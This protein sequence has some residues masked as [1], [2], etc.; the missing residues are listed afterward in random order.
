M[1]ISLSEHF[2]YKKLF[3]FTLPSIAMMIF[4]SVYGIVDG[5]FVSNIVG[6]TAFTAVNFIMPVLMITGSVG[7]MFGAGGSALVA[8]TLGEGDR[9]KANRIFSLIVYTSFIV[10]VI[11][12]ATGFVL[13]RTIAAALGAEG[14]MLENCVL[15]G[16]IVVSAIPMFMLQMEFQSLFITAEKPKLGLAVTVTAGVMNMIL[17]ALFMAV[18]RWGVAGAAAATAISQI[19][20][21][22]IPLVYFFHENDSLLRLG[23][24]KPDLRALGKTCSNGSSEFVSQGSM[25]LV[26][27]LYNTQLIRYAG[28]GGVAA[29]GVMM[30]VNLVFLA[31]FIGYSVGA[32]P[33]VGYNFGAKNH[34]ELKNLRRK[35]IRIIAA[36]SVIML[37]VSELSAGV[38]AGIFVGSNEELYALTVRGFKIFSIS[39]LFAGTNIF[40]SSFFTALN[41]GLISAL[42]SFL[43]T[44][45]FQISAVI[46]LPLFFETDG[47]FMSVSAAELAAFVLTV[48]FLA[49]KR[50]KYNY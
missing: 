1:N 45:V 22:V 10:G 25:S 23:R 19:V 47:I 32:A 12:A 16:R 7:F 48:A 9:A 11:L 8:K 3:L 30:Y 37:A 41:N 46:V 33:I 24:T 2:T 28:E 43:R 15:Y 18:F 13:M 31:I 26:N 27:M 35:S 4:T 14:E 40:G 49:A 5:L 50:K 6:E 20:G 44:L 38:F 21:G 29:Y 36:S 17:D 39:F 42:I 34:D